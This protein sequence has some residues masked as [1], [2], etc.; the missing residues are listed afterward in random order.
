M[1]LKPSIF[2]RIVILFLVASAFPGFADEGDAR[3]TWFRRVRYDAYGGIVGIGRL[4]V[5]EARA[6]NAYRFVSDAAGRLVE[7]SY[8]RSGR[9]L[10]DPFVGV[11]RIE[12]S[13]EEK[14][15]HYRYTDSRGMPVPDHRGVWAVRRRLDDAGRVVGIYQYDRY[16]NLTADRS[17]VAVR[18]WEVDKKG[19]RILE[20]YFDHRG[21]RITDARGTGATRFTWD[22]NDRLIAVSYDDLD[23]RPVAGLDDAVHRS[24]YIH[25]SDGEIVLENRYD[26]SGGLVEGLDG[27]AVIGYRR[28]ERGLPV[29]ERR[30][31][32]DNR[33]RADARG[34]ALYIREYDVAGNL[35]RQEHRDAKGR[36]V[37]DLAGVT[38]Y[39]WI[40]YPQGNELEQLNL[41]AVGHLVEDEAGMASY[42]WE[43]DE[44]GLIVAST[45]FGT[46][47]L[48]K[49]DLWGVA[50][51]RHVYDD[52]ENLVEARSYADWE[53]LAEDTGGVAIYRWD[54]DRR[55]NRV[56]ERHYDTSDTFVEDAQGIA[57]YRWVYD[58]EGNKIEQ[59]QYGLFGQLRSDPDGVAVYTWRY[60]GF[61]RAVERRHLGIDERPVDNVSG[62]ALTRW[63]YD[64][65]GRPLETSRFDRRTLPTY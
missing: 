18:L 7:V 26:A 35:V 16:E 15:I 1:D 54:Y 49:Q 8:H 42:R 36:L 39:Q 37:A 38:V 41:D 59:R 51:Y 22:E 46:D 21:G 62:A 19:R 4:D 23:G 12:I 50:R 20:R 14:D 5:A 28:D 56:L 13:Y 17:G 3:E 30:F 48:P 33:P 63:T 55:G 53:S 29:E 32:T 44:R 60:D 52:R 45:S 31:G 25:D 57:E 43:Y 10:A 40:H 6:V 27:S 58:T 24:T 2:Y 65:D 61:G 34:V 47:D 9:S 64:A 11:N